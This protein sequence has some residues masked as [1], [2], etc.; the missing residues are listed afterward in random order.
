MS[1]T[2]AS[3]GHCNLCLWI[4][5]FGSVSLSWHVGWLMFLRSIEKC[6]FLWTVL[7]LSEYIK[8]IEVLGSFVGLPSTNGGRGVMMVI[9]K[10]KGGERAMISETAHNSYSVKVKMATCQDVYFKYRA[11]IEFLAVGTLYLSDIHRRLERF[12]GISA[13]S[14]NISLQL[15]SEEKGKPMISKTACSLVTC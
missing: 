11:V 2:G 6:C 5:H 12:T 4:L 14:A 9:E 8:L 15:G 10:W 1:R 7:S 3:V 13:L